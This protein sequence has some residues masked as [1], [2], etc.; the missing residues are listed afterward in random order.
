[1]DAERN[2][3][4]IKMIMVVP[5]SSF[6]NSNYC[7][8]IEKPTS[9]K[10]WN[11]SPKSSDKDLSSNID[12]SLFGFP[13]PRTPMIQTGTAKQEMLRLFVDFDSYK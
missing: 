9:S 2:E 12:P 13:A 4:L 6:K 10:R 3:G 5:I 1:M 7:T 11:G 8:L